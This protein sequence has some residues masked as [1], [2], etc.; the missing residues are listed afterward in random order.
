MKVLVIINHISLG[1]SISR[2]LSFINQIP[3]D[4]IILQTLVHQGSKSF[5]NY[6]TIVIETHDTNAVD[7]G[8]QFGKVFESN[9]IISTFFFTQNYFLSGYSIKDLPSNCFYIPLQIKEFLDYINKSEFVEKSATKLER[10]LFS[11][12]LTSSHH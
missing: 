2:Y 5:L 11:N 1:K 6:N 3:S 10:V 7:Y 8:V 4:Y 9:G 12:P